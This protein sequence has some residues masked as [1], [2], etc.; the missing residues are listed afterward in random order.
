MLKLCEVLDVNILVQHVCEACAETYH[1]ADP[2]AVRDPSLFEQLIGKKYERS[3]C[4]RCM[5]NGLKNPAISDPSSV[6]AYEE[7]MAYRL[8]QHLKTGLMAG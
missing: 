7:A 5:T 6:P 3:I 4:R 8:S 2:L 1:E